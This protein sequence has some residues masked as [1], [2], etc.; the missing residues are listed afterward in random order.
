MGHYCRICGRVR[1]NE[2]FSASGRR[3]HVCA[4]CK[5]LAAKFDADEEIDNFLR[6]SHIS[7]K[8]IARLRQIAES[9]NRT[10]AERAALI[11]EVALI[12]PYKRHRMKRLA[13]GYSD[14]F[15]KLVQSGLADKPY[16]LDRVETMDVDEELPPNDFAPHSTPL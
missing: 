13:R 15:A 4:R 2:A 10:R 1:A 7:A 6:Q 5:H 14:L 9:G 3:R 11:L 8:N 12:A 16:W